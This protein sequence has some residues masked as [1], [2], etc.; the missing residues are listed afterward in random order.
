MNWDREFI[1]VPLLLGD[2]IEMMGK[3]SPSIKN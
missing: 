3:I 1:I 2:K